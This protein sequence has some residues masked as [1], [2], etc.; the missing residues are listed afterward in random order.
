MIQNHTTPWGMR[1]L[2]DILAFGIG[3]GAAYFSFF[4]HAVKVDSF[5]VFTVVYVVYFFPWGEVKWL[6][7]R[8]ANK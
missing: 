2:P 1:V 3:L 7:S 4:C 8:A 6:K 5:L